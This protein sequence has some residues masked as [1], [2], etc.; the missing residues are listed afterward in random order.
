MG[1]VYPKI[2]DLAEGGSGG[3]GKTVRVAGG[4][5]VTSELREGKGCLGV[6]R[7]KFAVISHETQERPLGYRLLGGEDSLGA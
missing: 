7:R 4:G 6:A 5:V 3:V 2:P 1:R